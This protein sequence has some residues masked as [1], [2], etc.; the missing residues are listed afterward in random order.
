L[1]RVAP[2]RCEAFL[3]KIVQVALIVPRIERRQ[4]ERTLFSGLDRYLADPKVGHRF[5]QEHWVKIYRDGLRPF[6]QNL[7]DVN[8]YL[9]SFGFP[10]RP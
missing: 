3:E 7:R 5:A 6:F 8:R 10:H 9:S 1:E 2:D 4:L